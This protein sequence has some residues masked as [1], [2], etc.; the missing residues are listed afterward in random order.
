MNSTL[1][2][3]AS[4]SHLVAVGIDDSERPVR[5]IVAARSDEARRRLVEHAISVEAEVVVTEPL[6]EE[7]AI[8]QLLIERRVPLWIVPP[9]I[10][11]AVLRATMHRA[12][13]PRA[14]AALL[15]RLVR[16]PELYAHLR[17]IPPRTDERQLRLF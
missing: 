13:G 5:A 7:D 2:I 1:G 15:A 14:Y 10:V 9:G 17:R 3:W 4:R 6:L 8:G 12:R 11:L 16:E